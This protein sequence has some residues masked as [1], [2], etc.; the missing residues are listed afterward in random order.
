MTCSEDNYTA[1]SFNEIE[2]EGKNQVVFF[3]L[4]S[5][6]VYVHVTT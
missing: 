2:F 4:Q 1:C 6:D 3:K 5:R